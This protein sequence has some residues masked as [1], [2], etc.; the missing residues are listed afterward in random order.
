MPDFKG[1][2]LSSTAH[3]HDSE[4]DLPSRWHS[5]LQ[6]GR[7]GIESKTV[8]KGREAASVTDVGKHFWSQGSEESIGEA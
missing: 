5:I 2:V 3:S 1:Q 4:F 6:T 8:S 7:D